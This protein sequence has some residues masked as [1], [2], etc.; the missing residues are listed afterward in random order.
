MKKAKLIAAV[1][2]LVMA[3]GSLPYVQYDSLNTAVAADST[4]RKPNLGDPNGDGKIN[5]IDASEI[6]SIYSRH[7][8]QKTQPSKEEI[9]YCDVDYNGKVN[10]TD[11]SYVLSYYVYMS[12][13]TDRAEYK[14]NFFE[15]VIMSSDPSLFSHFF[16]VE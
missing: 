14:S 2:A 7:A 12:T 10:A 1:A 4:A 11:A 8:T 13:N 6:L 3:G 5:A 15:F 9:N 16:K